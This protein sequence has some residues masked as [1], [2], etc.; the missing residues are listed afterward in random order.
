MLSI[1]NTKRLL[2]GFSFLSVL[3][4]AGFW[5]YITRPMTLP[6]TPH[7]P[8][9]QETQGLNQAQTPS[10]PSAAQWTALGEL[11]LRRRLFDPVAVVREEPP[12]PPPPP[13]TVRLVG[14]IVEPGQS[15]AIFTTRGGSTQIISPGQTL[16]DITLLEVEAKQVTIQRFGQTLT[17]KLENAS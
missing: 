9:R 6:D 10:I 14:T 7:R 3:G 15:L 13:M 5:V 2:Y 8:E 12:P 16:E 4:A 17:L 11:D 1:R